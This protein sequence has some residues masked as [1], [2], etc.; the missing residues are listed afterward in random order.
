MWTNF[1]HISEWDW[2]NDN[3]QLL[4]WIDFLLLDDTFPRRE[5]PRHVRMIYMNATVR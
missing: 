5:L 2:G 4:N 3:S 1:Y